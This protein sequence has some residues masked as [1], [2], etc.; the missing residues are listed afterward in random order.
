[1]TQSP[2]ESPPSDLQVE[3]SLDETESTETETDESEHR[4]AA[5]QLA[6]QGSEVQLVLENVGARVDRQAAIEMLRRFQ[7]NPPVP[8]DLAIRQGA[9]V[10]SPLTDTLNRMEADI[11]ANAST[12][13]RNYN[14]SRWLVVAT[15]VSALPGVGAVLYEAI[16]NAVHKEPDK[17]GLTDEEQQ[18]VAALAAAWTSLPDDDYWRSL[19]AYVDDPDN[20]LT[21]YDQLLFMN[22]TVDLSPTG[23][24]I[25]DSGDDV[26]SRADELYDEYLDSG[27]F[28]AMYRH[29]SGMT[30]HDRPIP[31][32]VT[33]DLLRYALTRVFAAT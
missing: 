27:T 19:A 18:K 28:G 12:E 16:R 22:Y 15:V 14:L 17:L 5:V 26:I 3:E 29:A 24:W 8:P 13:A 20:K 4:E 33:A 11:R 2:L 10:L 23:T 30:Y 9:E 31:R 21:V 7:D 6:R 32:A 25:W 1:M